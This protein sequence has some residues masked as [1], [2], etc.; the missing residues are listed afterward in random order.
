MWVPRVGYVHC[1]LLFCIYQFL[2]SWM[3]YV[4]RLCSCFVLSC[5]MNVSLVLLDHSMPTGAT[6]KPRPPQNLMKFGILASVIQTYHNCLKII[7]RETPTEKWHLR[8]CSSSLGISAIQSIVREA[9]ETN[10]IKTLT[11]RQWLNVD[12]CNLEMLT[13]TSKEFVA[14]FVDYNLLLY[15]INLLYIILFFMRRKRSRVRGFFK[16]LQGSSKV[17]CTQCKCTLQYCKNTTNMK[18]H[19]VSQHDTMAVPV[20]AI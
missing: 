6:L 9:L 13:K 14:L 3:L 20:T 17:I 4:D 8:E 1:S 10:V 15:I 12:R 18:N 16:L 2:N 7:M 5:Y 19:I 11:F